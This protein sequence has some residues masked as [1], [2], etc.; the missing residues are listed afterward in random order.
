MKRIVTSFEDF[1]ALEGQMVGKSSNFLVSHTCL[2]NFIE[3]TNT[4]QEGEFV[5][6]FFVLSLTPYL[7]ND[8]VEVKNAKMIINYGLPEV[9]FLEKVIAG[10][11]VRLI[12]WISQANRKFGITKVEIEFAI[13]ICERKIKCAEGQAVFLYYF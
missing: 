10:E 13:E 7:W 5:P 2:S 12:V 6:D 3:S 11:S 4:I 1:K 8:I 9:R